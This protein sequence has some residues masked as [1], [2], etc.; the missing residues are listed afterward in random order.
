MSS[1]LG[2]RRRSDDDGDDDEAASPATLAALPRDLQWRLA[3]LMDP[4]SVHNLRATAWDFRENLGEGE[5][6]ASPYLAALRAYADAVVAFFLA[7]PPRAWPDVKEHILRY[8]LSNRPYNFDSPLYAMRSRVLGPFALRVDHMAR[9]PSLRGMP[10]P[11]A[12]C[13]PCAMK[14]A[15]AYS[16]L[17]SMW[18]PIEHGLELGE[19]SELFEPFVLLV[20]ALLRAIL[21]GSG[22]DEVDAAEDLQAAVESLSGRKYGPISLLMIYV[23][24]RELA[25]ELV[26]LFRE[27]RLECIRPHAAEAA[28]LR[29]LG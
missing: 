22:Q 20:A 25:P 21:M 8:V 23:R 24:L 14:F 12:R 28:R 29:A 9:S 10:P 19:G 13:P 18:Y 7:D 4:R 6:V 3:Q 1:A 16:V 5:L 11:G 2:R 15:D 17:G 26:R 27:A